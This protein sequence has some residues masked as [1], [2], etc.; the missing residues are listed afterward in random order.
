MRDKGA[1]TTNVTWDVANGKLVVASHV[2]TRE[3]IINR[4]F[5]ISFRF[6]AKLRMHEITEVLLLFNIKYRTK[7]YVQTLLS[8]KKESSTY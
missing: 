4:Q 3:D 2:L 5:Q 1:R 8:S 6:K 7:R